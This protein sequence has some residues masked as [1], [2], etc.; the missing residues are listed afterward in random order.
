MYDPRV[1]PRL[2]V[3]LAL[4]TAATAAHAQQY[5]WV[6]EKGRVHYT[7][8]PPPAAAKK[9]EKKNLKGNS[10]GEQPNAQLGQ[11]AK[12]SPVTLYTH[13]ECTE[14]CAMAREVLTK[15]GV[16]FKEVAATSEATIA[17]LKSVSGGQE[18][19][20]LVVGA[21]VEKFA[22]AHAYERALDAA[23]YPSRGA[24][25]AREASAAPSQ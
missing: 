16:P 14:A 4:C 21:R 19:P 22:T 12:N 6:D 7:D 5:R 8:T 20:V 3:V 15:R 9:V 17:E 18:V 23:G 13:P 11:A 25:P 2:I 24:V 1:S 10:V